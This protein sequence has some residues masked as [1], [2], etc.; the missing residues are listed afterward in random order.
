[1]APSRVR[2]SL[3]KSEATEEFISRKKPDII[4]IVYLD[5]A[6]LIYNREPEVAKVTNTGSGPFTQRVCLK[7]PRKV[8]FTTANGRE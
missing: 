1:M 2:I 7:N 4:E 5:L 3:A 6:K 8:D